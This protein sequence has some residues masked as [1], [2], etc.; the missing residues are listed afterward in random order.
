MIY[1]KGK[2]EASQIAGGRPVRAPLRKVDENNE[3]DYNTRKSIK[4]YISFWHKIRA[5]Q[6]FFYKSIRF[7]YELFIMIKYNKSTFDCMSFTAF[8]L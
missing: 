6:Y 8:I 3:E 4:N 1:K 2:L 5:S 7:I